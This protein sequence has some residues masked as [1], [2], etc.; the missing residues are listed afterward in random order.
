VYKRQAIT[1]ASGTSLT[2]SSIPNYAKR[3]TVSY[4]GLT[5]NG[6][7]P[8]Q[9]QLVAG[10]TVTTG[11]ATVTWEFYA[12]STASTTGFNIDRA[13]TS[14]ASGVL[15]SGV[16]TF[17]NING[18]TWAGSGTTVRTSTSVTQTLSGSITLG[19]SLTGIV[20]TTV[21]G[22]DAFTAGLIN[23]LYE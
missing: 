5:T 13:T 15:R 7:S 16:V 8:V 19:S 3:V 21:N 22:T 4:S 23:I 20:I 6:T 12:S 11:Y 10:T 2:F 17:V 9:I 1:S 18:N 14:I